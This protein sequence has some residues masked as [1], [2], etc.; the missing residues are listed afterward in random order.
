MRRVHGGKRAPWRRLLLVA[1][2]GGIKSCGPGASSTWGLSSSMDTLINQRASAGV[3]G[4][5]G[6]AAEAVQSVLTRGAGE[7][8]DHSRGNP[9][10]TYRYA[11]K[12]RVIQSIKEWECWDQW[13]TKEGFTSGNVGVSFPPERV[14]SRSLVPLPPPPPSSPAHSSPL[15]R[16]PFG[17]HPFP[18]SL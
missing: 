10:G 13:M 8:L 11:Y 9:N 12:W 3:G 2:T 5:C 17:S 1:P 6:G 16:F 14:S 18:S 15:I 4:C 7:G